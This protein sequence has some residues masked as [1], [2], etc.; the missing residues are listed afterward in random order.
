M[1]SICLFGKTWP[2]NFDFNLYKGFCMGKKD[3][4]SSDFFLKKIPKLGTKSSF[5]HYLSKTI[6]KKLLQV[7]WII[8]FW[9]FGCH[10]LLLNFIILTFLKLKLPLQ[11]W[12]LTN[13]I[14]L[15][16]SCRIPHSFFIFT[17]I[18]LCLSWG[19]KPNYPKF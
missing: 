3:P 10:G 19:L 2:E 11:S 16:W 4:N 5:K 9:F 12:L 13:M 6:P 8:G 14:H 18:L 17:T 1:N 15:I 7:L